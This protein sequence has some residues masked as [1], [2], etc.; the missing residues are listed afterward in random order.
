MQQEILL[1]KFNFVEVELPDSDMSNH[2]KKQIRMLVKRQRNAK[3]PIKPIKHMK[4]VIF[5][6]KY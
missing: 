4:A 3:K 6:V 1:A 5:F 2:N